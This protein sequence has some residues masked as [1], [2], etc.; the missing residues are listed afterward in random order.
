[1]KHVVDTLSVLDDYLISSA[2][3][4]NVNHSFLCFPKKKNSLPNCNTN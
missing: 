1:M 3:N 2:I 4:Y